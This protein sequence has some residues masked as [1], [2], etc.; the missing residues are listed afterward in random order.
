MEVQEQPSSD[1]FRSEKQ[2]K[3]ETTFLK[4]T[5]DGIPLHPQ[6][7]DDPEDPLVRRHLHLYRLDTWTQ[8]EGDEIRGAR[9]PVN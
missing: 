1:D 9:D 2:D 3:P 8:Q 7:S 4:A 5:K 6:P